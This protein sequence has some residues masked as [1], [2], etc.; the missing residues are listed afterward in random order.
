MSKFIKILVAS[1]LHGNL[2]DKGAVTALLDFQK[3]FKPDQSLFLGDLYDFLALMGKANSE[4]K[5]ESLLADYEVGNEFLRK[6]HPQVLIDG[7]HDHRMVKLIDSHDAVKAG[8]AGKIMAEITNLCLDLRIHHIPYNKYKGIYKIGNLHFA[9]GFGGGPLKMCTSFGNVLYGHEHNFRFH[10]G[11]TYERTMAQCVGC[12]CKTDMEYNSAQLGT[13]SQENGFVAG[14][15][16]KATG[17][18]SLY[19]VK[20]LDGKYIYPTTFA[21]L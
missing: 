15:I 9:H 17:N 13:F 20:K 3:V 10:Q 1:D 5:C 16:S 8:L 6:F 21:G 2:C 12:L 19:T 14:V 11:N 18:F 4:D 7:N